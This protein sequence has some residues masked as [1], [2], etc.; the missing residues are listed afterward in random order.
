MKKILFVEDDPVVT[1]IYSRKLED[2][3]FKVMM[4]EDGLVAMKVLVSFVPDVLVLD[5]LMPKFNGVDV[6]RFMRNHA[7][8][9][10]VPTIVFSNALLT[11]LGEQ[12]TK[13]G[14]HASLIKSSSTPDLL[15]ETINKL[16]QPAPAAP[17]TPP[18]TRTAAYTSAQAAAA[19]QPEPAPV[20]PPPKP[21]TEPPGPA[22]GVRAQLQRH[23]FSQ[24]P[25]ICE[26]LVK[27]ARDFVLASDP[28]LQFQKI[29]ALRKK[30]GFVTHM[31]GMAGGYRIAQLSGTLE[32]LLFKLQE[33]TSDINKSSQ[34]TVADTVA[35]L[36]ECLTR[37][38]EADEQCMSPTPVLIVDDDAVSNLALTY[39]LR[40]ANANATTVLDPFTALK[41]LN[42]A[43]FDVVILDINLPGMTGLALCEEMRKLPQ[44]ADVPV[45]FVT[46]YPEF[47]FRPN[48]ALRPD[49]D[50]ITK[51]VLP[52][53]LAVKVV[54]YAMKRRLSGK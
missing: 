41:K 9:K 2:A 4:A 6:L 35:F 54:A 18:T 53:E 36:A 16:F 37:A 31:A 14:V 26:S 8:L 21:A 1:R 3:G 48:P 13:L 22:A 45:I 52:V 51:P 12:V 32:A 24:I 49:D 7:E 39:A 47:K 20:A 5:I 34:H 42:Q 28:I 27:L 25:A 15:V 11:E 50:W 29:E 23:F 10:S 40:K 19:G 33:N 43:T 44:Y 38:E 17:V 46:G 30:V